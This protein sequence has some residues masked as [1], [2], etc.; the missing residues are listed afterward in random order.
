MDTNVIFQE[1]F[2]HFHIPGH[3]VSAQDHPEIGAQIGK[4]ISG[5]LQTLSSSC[6][7][8]DL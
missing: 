8:K 1:V 3:L 5:M 2:S 6:T 7:Q 4:T